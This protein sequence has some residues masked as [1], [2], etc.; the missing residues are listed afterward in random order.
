MKLVGEDVATLPSFP[1][2]TGTIT[3]PDKTT[4]EYEVPEADKVTRL[5]LKMGKYSS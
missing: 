3:P 1:T 5:L 2:C 4:F